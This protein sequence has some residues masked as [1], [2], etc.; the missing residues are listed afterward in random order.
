MDDKSLGCWD[1]KPPLCF[2]ILELISLSI[3]SE[4]SPRKHA[5]ELM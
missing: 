1:D 4:A 2:A 3:S 5:R